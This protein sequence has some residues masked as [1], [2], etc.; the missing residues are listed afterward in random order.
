MLIFITFNMA[1]WQETQRYIDED[2]GPPNL[3]LTKTVLPYARVAMILYTFGRVILFLLSLKF[4]NV[5]KSFLYYEVLNLVIYSFLPY[6]IT[7]NIQM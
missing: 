4:P 5:S 2:G 6:D 7:L 3:E 1:N